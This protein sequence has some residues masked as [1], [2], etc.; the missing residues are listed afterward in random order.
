[1]AQTG[2]LDE[3]HNL[4]M[5]RNHKMTLKIGLIMS[6]VLCIFSTPILLVLVDL[7]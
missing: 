2:C 1:M 4:G 6:M 5:K 7:L 3:D